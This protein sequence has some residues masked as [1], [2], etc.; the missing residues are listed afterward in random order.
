MF[1]PP[2]HP[3]PLTPNKAKQDQTKPNKGGWGK[4]ENP[5][6]FRLLEAFS[7]P[8]KLEFLAVRQLAPARV[9]HMLIGCLGCCGQRCHGNM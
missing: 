5:Y 1:F 6:T 8:P 3:H 7:R 2:P 4:G 9:I